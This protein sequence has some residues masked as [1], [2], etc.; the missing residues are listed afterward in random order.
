MNK[1]DT[2]MKER[3]LVRAVQSISFKPENQD[4]IM[5]RILC[6][7]KEGKGKKK[8]SKKKILAFALAATMLLGVTVMAASGIITNWYSSSSSEPE[9]TTLPSIEQCKEDVGYEAILIDRFSNGYVFKKGDVVSNKLEDNS[10]NTVETFKSLNFKYEKEGDEVI[11]SQDRY[12][13]PTPSSGD[14]VVEIDGIKVYYT[15]YLNKFVPGDYQMTEEDKEAEE[16]GELVF[17]YGTE[18]VEIVNVQSICWAD[19][20]IHY[21]LMQMDGKLSKE[22]M[23]EMAKEAISK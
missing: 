11:F 14:I 6:S 22:E 13:S 9:Y 23:I 18:D 10:G 15:S 19:G 20:D 17:S 7:V 21:D 16:K 4:R 1:G 3:E 12:T 5:E 2:I 8:M